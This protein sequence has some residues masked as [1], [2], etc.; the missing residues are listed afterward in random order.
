MRFI[1][2]NKKQ[3]IGLSVFIMYFIIADLLL[4]LLFS[5]GIDISKSSSLVKQII[6]LGINLIFPILLI[7]IYRKDL[8]NYIKK[9]KKN[10]REYLEVGIT[11]Y[12]IG[13]VGMVLSNLIIQYVFNL[14]LANNETSVREL[15]NS[16]P[17]YMFLTACIIAP[18]QEE[19]VFRKT[20]KDIFKNKFFFVLFS[21]LIF[22]ALHVVGSLTSFTDLIYIIPYGFLGAMFALILSKTDNILVPISIHLIHNTVLVLLQIYMM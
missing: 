3:L 15:I 8:F 22:G 10:Y 12:M 5:F 2:K 4:G 14:G 19:M 6:T 16:A 9:V 13:L 17:V 7:I 11:Y 18:F 1:R 20:F 21:G